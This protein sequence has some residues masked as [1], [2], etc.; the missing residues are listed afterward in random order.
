MCYKDLREDRS[1]VGAPNQEH[2]V[3]S[4]ELI[5]LAAREYHI[6]T[7]C[8]SRWTQDPAHHGKRREAVAIGVTTED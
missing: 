1:D 2:S 8:G 7:A 5:R 6:V 3:I 4:A